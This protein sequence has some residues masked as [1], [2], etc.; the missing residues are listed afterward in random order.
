MDMKHPASFRVE[1]ID[2]GVQACLIGGGPVVLVKL[3]AG[4]VHVDEI[5]SLQRSFVDAACSDQKA[6]CID[7]TRIISRSCTSITPA[8]KSVGIGKKVLAKRL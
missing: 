4:K 8:C 6:L 7:T 3:M 2:H 5:A 1:A